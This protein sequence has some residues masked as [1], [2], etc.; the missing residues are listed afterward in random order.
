MGQVFRGVGFTGTGAFRWPPICASCGL[1]ATQ[2]LTSNYSATTDLRFYGFYISWRS[3]PI[4]VD[5]PVCWKHW[6]LF[7]IP[8]F[9]ARE[10]F[11][12]LLLTIIAG[13]LFIFGL[14]SV[15]RFVLGLSPGDESG[16][17]G[18]MALL[19][20][21]FLAILGSRLAVPVRVIFYTPPAIS[22]RIRDHAYAGE[23]EKL[24]SLPMPQ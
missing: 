13:F 23:F 2:R 17:L 18:T 9:L 7:L 4:A 14:A 20:G 21:P 11:L 16:G 3:H 6:L 15:L 22:V 24:N 12:W 8:N 10:S 1:P 5:Y 19:M